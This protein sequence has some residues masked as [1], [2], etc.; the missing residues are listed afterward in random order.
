M[1][2]ITTS[3]FRIAES[4]HKVNTAA[5]TLDHI[6]GQMPH[7]MSPP[8]SAQIAFMSFKLRSGVAK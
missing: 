4:F 1:T 2:P 8:S 5:N 6:H 3:T 7:R